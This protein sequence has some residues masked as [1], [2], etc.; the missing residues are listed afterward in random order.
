M[1]YIYG[2]YKP[3]EDR[4]FYV[5]KGKG[6]RKLSSK[7]R[8][9]HWKHIVNKYFLDTNFPVVK[10][11]SNNIENESVAFDLERFWIALF[12]RQCVN[13]GSLINL[14]VGGEGPAGHKRPDLTIRNLSNN[15]SRIPE[16]RLK[17]KIRMKKRM[18]E[19]NILNDPKIKENF[20]KA[21]S[22][23]DFRLKKSKQNGFDGCWLVH[24][25]HGRHWC[26]N[27]HEFAKK[28]NLHRSQLSKMI[29]GTHRYKSCKQWT[30]LQLMSSSHAGKRFDAEHKHKLAIGK[31]GIKNPMYGRSQSIEHKLKIANGN[32]FG[33]C[34][35]IHPEQGRVWCAV[36][37][38]F[39]R[40]YNMASSSVNALIKGRMRTCYGWTVDNNNIGTDIL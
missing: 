24:P 27:Q 35:L 19:N 31:I 13:E 18:L 20:K 38:E 26:E 6:N 16:V 34:W 30:L 15:P 21:I 17:N 33:G 1:Y 12:G 5:G 22:S 28:W 11:L 7:N 29:A 32:G 10:I 23:R 9:K 36:Q 8:T 40:D 4:P 37:R 2:H 3:N 39:A 14:S 25:E